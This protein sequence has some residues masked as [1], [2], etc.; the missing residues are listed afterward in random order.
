MFASSFACACMYARARARDAHSCMLQRRGADVHAIWCSVR[1]PAQACICMCS[2][3]HVQP[4]HFFLARVA[5][6]ALAHS[7]RNRCRGTQ[8]PCTHPHRFP[9][10]RFPLA[11]TP[12]TPSPTQ[13][14]VCL[15]ST[16]RCAGGEQAI[17]GTRLRL[18]VFLVCQACG[19]RQV[20]V[21]MPGVR[22]MPG[23]FCALH[24]FALHERCTLCATCTKWYGTCALQFHQW[25]A[26]RHSL[27]DA[28]YTC[29]QL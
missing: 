15:S 13:C 8:R 21:M 28:T 24:G 6:R 11:A 26:C 5:R 19:A 25:R 1:L 20:Y 12:L 27:L 4:H 29:Q 9:L 7:G 18:C 17:L 3:M 22:C 16:W 2:H 14:Q 10:A 23:V